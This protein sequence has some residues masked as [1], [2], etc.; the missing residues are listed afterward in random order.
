MEGK[1]IMMIGRN[2]FCNLGFIRM[3]APIL[4]IFVLVCAILPD[5]GGA[6]TIAEFDPERFLIVDSLS[7]DGEI[8][9]PQICPFDSTWMAYEIHRD[10]RIQLVVYKMGAGQYRLVNPAPINDS[11]AL[12]QSFDY[13]IN[14]DFAWRPVSSEDR[15][16][17]AYVSDSSGYDRILLYDVLSDRSYPL[18]QNN[19]ADSGAVF[20]IWGVPDWS[21]DGACLTYSAKIADDADI[22]LIRGMDEILKDPEKINNARKDTPLV[23][24]AGNQF[25]AAWCPVQGSGYLAFTEQGREDNGF[26]I[27]VFDI[28]TSKAF[29]LSE[30]DTTLD[31]FSPTWNAGGNRISFYRYDRSAG[32]L[33]RYNYPIDAKFEVGVATVSVRQDSLILVPQCGGHQGKGCI[34]EVAPNFDKLLGPAWLPGGRHLVVTRYDEPHP[35]RLCVISLPDWEAGETERDYWLR[36][37]GGGRFDYP[38]DLNIVNRNVSFTYKNGIQNYLLT[39]RIIPS[40]K[41]VLIPEYLDVEDNRRQ[42]WR[43]YAGG[44]ESS[45]GNFFTR[46]GNF[47]WAP[48][49]GPDIGINKR[50]VP[51][52]GGLVLLAV[53]LGGGDDDSEAQPHDWSP[54]QFPESGKIAPGFKV[55]IGFGTGD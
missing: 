49:A 51:I 55:T 30:A 43:H 13:G 25:G 29:G 9:R 42:W 47:L 53:L 34:I 28:L 32:P 1:N 11:V 4:L 37:F 21:P 19:D 12:S 48:I 18:V 40:I 26:R 27:R 36:G 15:L 20:E 35:S 52:A 41:L 24:G 5:Y 39:G 44:S 50:I 2:S 17:A 33:S 23:G 46:A 38:R 3:R 14:R 31:Y 22:Y 8:A 16:W 7:A 54:P 45:G 6:E 10:G